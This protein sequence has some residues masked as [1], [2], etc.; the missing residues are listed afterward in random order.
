DR[1]YW[2]DVGTVDSYYDVHADLV[3]IDPVFNLYNAEWLIFMNHRP[4]S[5]AKFVE[6]GE[7]HE[8]IVGSGCVLAGAVVDY[9]VL[10]PGVQVQRGAMVEASV[11]MEDTVIGPGAVVRRAILDKGIVVPPGVHI[12]VD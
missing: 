10:S 1:Y 7:A 11:V 6:G 2:R 8:S 9:S 5:G 4:L 3:S 12:G